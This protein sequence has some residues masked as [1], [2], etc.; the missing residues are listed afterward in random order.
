[1]RGGRQVLEEILEVLDVQGLVPRVVRGDQAVADHGH[2]RA[3]HAPVL[4][5]QQA[6]HGADIAVGAYG[7]LHRGVVDH[8]LDSHMPFGAIAGVGDEPLGDHCSQVLGQ[9]RAAGVA[10]GGRD[11]LAGGRGVT[12]VHRC[13][14]EMP[15][16]G[17]RQAQLEMLRQTALPEEHD[18]G[19]GAQGRFEGCLLL[20]DRHVSLADHGVARR[21][22]VL[23]G[24]L[25]GEDVH[26][27][28]HV[29]PVHQA[30]E[31]GRLA[32]ARRSGGYYQAVGVGEQGVDLSRQPELAQLGREGR[33][34]AE[35]RPQA[36]GSAV[37]RE[38]PPAAVQHDRL[39]GV[40]PGAQLVRDGFG[41]LRADRLEVGHRS[42]SAAMPYPG[43][44]AFGYVHV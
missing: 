14:H 23:D 20:L 21:V 12:R 44:S 18:V 15:C 28:G 19:I 34:S 30:G 22:Q 6:L 38:A 43:R 2:Q 9:S 10:G 33:N 13:E 16:R 37:A 41:L 39:R 7:L 8:Y 25:D 3:V 35:T 4:V 17:E 24:V 26:R 36:V 32:G 40:R 11:P 5:A 27:F 29:D 42:E 31:G 1:M